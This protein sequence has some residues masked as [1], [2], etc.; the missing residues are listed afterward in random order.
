MP[1]LVNNLIP[2]GTRRRSIYELGISAIRVI[3]REGLRTFWFHT[4]K[5]I[6]RSFSFHFSNSYKNWI[7]K[8][9]PDLNT[10]KL[11]IV[12]SNSFKYRPKISIIM[13][14]W[15]TDP[16]WLRLA[17]ESVIKQTYS[18]WELCI[19][20]GASTKQAVKEVLNTYILETR[21]KI[22]YLSQNKGISGNSNEAIS[23]ATGEFIALLDHDDELVPFALYEIVK[24]LN[25]KPDLDLIYSDED[26][27]SSTNDRLEPCF[28]PDWSPDYIIS[29]MY[30]GHLSVYRKTIIDEI[31]GF[32]L[33]YDGSQD[34]DLLLRFIGKT[35]NIYHIPK[36]LYHWRMVPGS[37]ASE[38]TAKPYAYASTKKALN[39]YMLR[40]GISGSLVDGPW[41]GS[42]RL[43]R[44]IAGNPMVSI[45]IDAH[46]NSD[47]LKN[48]LESILNKTEYTNYEILIIN[49]RYHGKNIIEANSKVTLLEYDNPLSLSSGYN[50]AVQKAKGQYVIFL[51]DCIE[52]IPEDWLSSML[53]YSQINEVGAVG[54]Q[55]L[56][57]NKTI[58]HCGIIVG[59]EGLAGYPYQNTYQPGGRPQLVSNYSAV[60]GDC[61]MTRKSLFNEVSGFDTR[62]STVL[63]DI[64]YCLKIRKLDYK[65]VY[66]PYAKLYFCKSFREYS[67]DKTDKMCRSQEEI[68]Y[69]RSRWEQTIR[70][71]DPYYNPNLTL[72][73]GDFSLK[74]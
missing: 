42:Y 64:D 44:Q 62:L 15:N 4:R 21:I 49:N 32:R 54:A 16:V 7:I 47:L 10:L 5:R 58:Q 11:Q 25:A 71:G 17:I 1:N 26:K 31:Q 56:F 3:R 57:H 73:K 13:P 66:T 14:V 2:V 72:K 55:I 37:F 60:S 35:Q 20:E 52:V 34:Y 68:N 48:C 30:L 28:R 65:I 45:I 59:L 40:T 38:P 18:N 67:L 61:L 8:N 22:K 50:F 33:G 9:E 70:K 39:D 46:N 51:S 19:A 63:F 74:N 41:P 29:C 27:I 23:L 6:R 53:E 24:V 36:I 69:F 43:S 12:E